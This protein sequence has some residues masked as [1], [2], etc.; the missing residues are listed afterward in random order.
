MDFLPRNYLPVVGAYEHSTAGVGV[1]LYREEG[2]AFMNKY[3][4]ITLEIGIE[5]KSI[6]N[7]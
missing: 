5:M 6:I 2:V 7:K 1:K 4:V 3:V